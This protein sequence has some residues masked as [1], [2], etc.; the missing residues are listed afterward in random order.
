MLSFAISSAPIPS[1]LTN[2]ILTPD[3]S[4]IDISS[5]DK[6]VFTFTLNFTD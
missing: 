6:E 4:I 1:S 2:P 3:S 5:Y